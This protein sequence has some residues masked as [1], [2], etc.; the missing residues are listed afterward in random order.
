MSTICFTD[1]DVHTG[2]LLR[3]CKL[4]CACLSTRWPNKSKP[5]SRIIIESY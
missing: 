2:L 5:L 3:N 4:F 1:L